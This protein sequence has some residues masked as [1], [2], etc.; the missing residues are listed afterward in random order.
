MGRVFWYILVIFC[1]LLLAAVITFHIGSYRRM[2]SLHYRDKALVTVSVFKGELWIESTQRP[3]PQGIF[4]LRF[5]SFKPYLRVV[6]FSRK[7]E[8]TL[9]QM[10]AGTVWVGMPTRI[11]LWWFELPLGAAFICLVARA[12]FWTSYQ[13]R[14]KRLCLR[15]GYSLQQLSTT[16]C[17]ECG[18]DFKFQRSPRRILV[19][20]G[21]IASL[22]VSV[23]LLASLGITT[24][25]ARNGPHTY[26]P[27]ITDPFVI[28]SMFEFI[29]DEI[30]AENLAVKSI[31]IL[32]SKK[33]TW[34]S[35][36]IFLYRSH[37]DDRRTFW[38]KRS[39]SSMEITDGSS[40]TASVVTVPLAD[41]T[42]QVV[43]V[44]ESLDILNR[45]RKQRDVNLKNLVPRYSSFPPDIVVG[46]EENPFANRK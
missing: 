33:S 13:R 43:R 25:L 45:V 40:E 30:S 3:L 46:P 26:R 10:L 15:C 20:G 38:S 4:A 19:A 28:E 36:H 7:N 31:Q 41:G 21:L 23:Y 24:Q 32:D 22:I 12:R 27:P 39:E 35:T 37:R 11:P 2:A 34:R 14:R 29:P 9:Q 8:K 16:I 18:L 42:Q 44:R 6:D 1:G 5:D 17:P